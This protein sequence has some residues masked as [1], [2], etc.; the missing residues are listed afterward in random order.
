MKI[1]DGKN[2]PAGRLASFVAKTALKGEEVSIVNCDEVILTGR[3]K[4]IKSDFE[5]KRSRVGS[6][7]KGPKHPATSEKMVKRIIR[8]MLPNYREGR[9]RTA[10]K[11]IKCYSNIP[12]EIDGQKIETI[13]MKKKVKYSK[14]KEFVKEKFKE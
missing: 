7:Q 11:K 14:V 3:F 6:S 8:G 9:G 2:M 12:K 13:P 5:T 10:Y 4:A 1:I